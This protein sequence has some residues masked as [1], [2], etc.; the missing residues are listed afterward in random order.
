MRQLFRTTLAFAILCFSCTK[1]KRE[2]LKDYTV[3]DY[4]T[5]KL[6]LDTL[7]A[8]MQAQLDSTGTW[9]MEYT[10]LSHGKKRLIFFGSSH[11]RDI[12]HPQFKQIVNAFNKLNPQ[13]AFNEGGQVPE[14]R[15]YATIDSAILADGETGVLK[16]LCDSASI[17]MMNGDMENREEFAAL[18]KEFPTDQIYLYL[19]VER[20]LDG[21]RRGHY[22]GIALEQAWKDKFIS[23][24]VE[25]DFKLSLEA[26]SLDSLKSLYKKYLGKEFSLDSLE[27]VY[28]YYLVNDGPLG[29]VSRGT[30]VVRDR[31]LLEK[32]DK[33]LD[34]YDRVFVVFGGSHRIAVEPALKQIMT[35]P[36]LTQNE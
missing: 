8:K 35:K 5:V 15:K 18:Q 21:Y 25:S 32:I 9:T 6:Y 34:Q 24:L 31:A 29:D 26:Q 33:A 3:H 30:K 27:H 28:E 36:R 19:A 16:Y 2:G 4:R 12:S 22:P 20:F 7:N 13:I 17:K 11:V 23:Y 10:D 14:N 1:E